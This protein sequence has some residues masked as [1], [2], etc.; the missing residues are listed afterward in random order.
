MDNDKKGLLK[1]AANKML[2]LHGNLKKL[3]SVNE[4][5]EKR[6]QAIKLI[7]KQAELGYGEIPQTH[8]EL[9]EKIASLLNRDLSIVE[10]ALEITG[11]KL[12]MAELGNTDFS[13]GGNAEEDFQASILGDSY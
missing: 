1:Q 6:A 12:D 13:I 4:G 7:Y 5:Y 9:Q 2:E 10:K 8:R 3:A 11:G